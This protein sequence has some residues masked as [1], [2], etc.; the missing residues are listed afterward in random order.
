MTRNIGFIPAAEYVMQYYSVDQA[1]G[2]DSNLIVSCLALLTPCPRAYRR[3]FILP[4][5][6]GSVYRRE[7]SPTSMQSPASAQCDPQSG[8]FIDLRSA[9]SEQRRLMSSGTARLVSQEYLDP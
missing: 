2:N 9:T 1:R 8:P 7:H 3:P 4:Q 6:T 5:L